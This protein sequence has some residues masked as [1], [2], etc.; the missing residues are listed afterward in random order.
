MAKGAVK[1][2]GQREVIRA[3]DGL[4][5]D[6]SDLTD[7]NKELAG[8]LV[9][10]VRKNTRRKSGKLADSWI[11]DADP[12]RILFHNPQAYAP[13]QEFGS[14]RR[15]IEP[16]HAVAKAFEDNKDVITDGYADATRKRAKRRNIRVE[17]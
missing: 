15:S 6:M 2:E 9:Q 8:R 12:Q 16:T 5:K 11:P 4:A 10:S 17:H 1:V 14:E 3:F 7:E 13:V